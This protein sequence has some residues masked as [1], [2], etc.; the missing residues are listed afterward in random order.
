MGWHHITGW[1]LSASDGDA[2]AEFRVTGGNSAADQWCVCLLLI[3]GFIPNAKQRRASLRNTPGWR[4]ARMCE[5]VLAEQ[6]ALRI[7]YRGV[8][9]CPG[10]RC[11]RAL[12]GPGGLYDI[13]Y[14]SRLRGHTQQRTERSMSSCPV[15]SLSTISPVTVQTRRSPAQRCLSCRVALRTCVGAVLFFF[16]LIGRRRQPAVSD[17]HRGS[18]LDMGQGSLRDWVHTFPPIPNGRREKLALVHSRC[19]HHAV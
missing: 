3:H 17:S 11:M 12:S 14:V 10:W 18:R 1:R 5:Y 19:I 16:F 2:R 15:P 7:T 4:S 8:S 6:G 13:P 9:P